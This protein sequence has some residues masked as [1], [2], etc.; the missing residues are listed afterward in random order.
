MRTRRLY[1]PQPLGTGETIALASDSAHYVRNVLR[2]KNND[3]L[4]IF[5]SKGGEFKAK[6]LDVDRQ[7]VL[8][9]IGEWINRECESPL[10]IHLGL[11]ISRGER[12]DFAIQKAVELGVYQI[13]PIISERVVVHLNGKRQQ[14]KI[15]HWQDVAISACQQCGRNYVP[16]IENIH[17]INDWIKL[18]SEMKL[19]LDP[20]SDQP[21]PQ[22]ALS[23]HILLLCGPEGGF[24]ELEQLKIIEATFHPIRLG[25]RIL[26]TETAALTAIAAIQSLWGDLLLQ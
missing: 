23:T 18:E 17:L 14:K 4:T 5:N 13:V 19:C 1:L 10:K 15:R 16:R 22:Q 7:S 12:M 25:P 8:I 6:I 9:A 26:R 24:T 2:L 20:S 21:L 3:R 11:A